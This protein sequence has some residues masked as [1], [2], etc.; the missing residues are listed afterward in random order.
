MACR[1]IRNTNNEIVTVY[2]EN[3]QESKLYNELSTSGLNRLGATINPKQIKEKALELY[4]T[5]DTQLFKDW[6]STVENVQRDSNNEVDSKHLYD[7]AAYMAGEQSLDAISTEMDNSILKSLSDML[8]VEDEFIQNNRPVLVEYL[9]NQLPG[10][11]FTIKENGNITVLNSEALSSTYDAATVQEVFDRIPA[12]I[13]NLQS[14]ETKLT[15]LGNRLGIKVNYQDQVQYTKKDGTKATVKSTANSYLGLINISKGADIRNLTEEM[16]HIVVDSLEAA[17]NPLFYSMYNNIHK[18][19]IYDEVYEKYLPLYGNDTRMIKKEAMAQAIMNTIINDSMITDDVFDS[20]LRRW[21]NKVMEFLST[22]FSRIFMDPYVKTSHLMLEDAVEKANMFTV[23]GS[24]ETYARMEEN[25]EATKDPTQQAIQRTEQSIQPLVDKLK[26]HN[27]SLTVEA[28]LAEDYEGIAP[29][30]AQEDGKVDRYRGLPN[31]P[32]HGM[33]IIGRPSDDT[34]KNFIKKVGKSKAIEINENPYNII[35]RTHGTEGHNTLERISQSLLSR[36]SKAGIA[37][38]KGLSPQYTQG[39]FDKLV[40]AVKK[41]HK[42]AQE[43]E[44]SI[45]GPKGKKPTILLENTI[46]NSDNNPTVAGS[47]DVLVIYSD[48]TAGIFD[49]KFITPQRDPYVTG[50]GASTRLA[51]FPFLDKLDSYDIQVG[52]YKNMLTQNYGISR[53]RQSRIVPIHVRFQYDKVNKEFTDKVVLLQEGTDSQYLEHLPVANEL[54][55]INTIDK[56]IDQQIR[57]RRDKL[58]SYQTA[59]PQERDKLKLQIDKLTQNIQSLQV[60]HDVATTIEAG[61]SLVNEVN[62]RIDENDEVLQDGTINTKYLKTSELLD[63]RERLAFY[64]SIMDAHDYMELVKVNDKK[65]YDKI[66]KLIEKHAA[67]FGLTK[68]R[69]QMKLD[70]RA[71]ELGKNRGVQVNKMSRELGFRSTQFLN[72]SQIQEPA[73]EALYK[74]VDIDN[75]KTRKATNTLV[76]EVELAQRALMEDST[77]PNGIAVYDLILNPKTNNLQ[78]KYKKEFWEA[79]TSALESKDWKF[80][81]QHYKLKEDYKELLKHYKDLAFDAID[82]RYPD[83]INE[84]GNIVGKVQEKKRAA[85]K[86]RWIKRYDVINHPETAWLNK[87]LYLIA[88]L[89]DE[90]MEE[91][92]TE[93][94]NTIRNNIN[95]K[96]FYDLHVTKMLEF[97]KILGAKYGHNFVGNIHRDILDSVFHGNLSMSNLYES[98]MDGLQV[99]EHNL[100]YG[101]RNL[102]TGELKKSVPKLFLIPLK[103]ANDNIDPSLKSKD[104]AK[105]LI[106]MGTAAYNYKHK[107]ETLDEALTLEA[108]LQNNSFGE[109]MRTEAGEILENLAGGFESR[110]TGT[111]AKNLDAFQ[112]FMNYYWYGAKKSSKDVRRKIGQTTIS[113]DRAIGAARNY[114]ALKYLGLAMIPGMATYIGGRVN[115]MYQAI[116][117]RHITKKGLREATKRGLQYDNT[118][119][120][121][122]EHFE[123]YQSDLK[124]RKANDLSANSAT[125]ILTHDNFFAPYR[126]ADEALDRDVLFSMALNHG[127]DETGKIKRLS[128]L[129]EGAKSLVELSTV[130]D[131]KNWKKGSVMN[132]F[133]LEIEGLT[134]AE[135]IRFRNMSRKISR[136]V[137]GSMSNEDVNLVNTSTLG[138][139]MMQFKNWMPGTMEARFGKLEFDSILESFEEGTWKSWSKDQILLEGELQSY[140]ALVAKNVMR[141]GWEIATFGYGAYHADEKKMRYHFDNYVNEMVLLGDE[142]FINALANPEQL[143]VLFA[144]FVDMKRSNIKAFASELRTVIL[145]LMSIMFVGGDFDDDGKAD[146]R[147]TW[148]GR[149]L[150]RLL[151]RTYLEV[152]YYADMNEM[153]RVLTAPMP[154]VRF[155]VDLYRLFANTKD[156]IRDELFGENAPNDPTPFFYYGSDWIPGFNQVGGFFEVFKQDKEK[157]R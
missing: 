146:Y 145:F 87:S 53:I 88:E 122:A 29:I 148:L 19:K 16:A 142:R 94:Y 128:Q 151:N 138:Q 2:T 81:K 149:T 107:S 52:H 144:D 110:R 63:M 95:L 103:D 89:N 119:R 71:I 104:L 50:Y 140:T 17:N 60:R 35:K 121:F 5:K 43:T 77:L 114:L 41:V 57:Q 64:D 21:W 11:E 117:G 36:N 154:I 61:V 32:F 157:T 74:L 136:L 67:A 62:N 40:T 23:I 127:I 143:E 120:A 37:E 124:F 1:I 39:Q 153:Q 8:N 65:L 6:L 45:P 113:T 132:K 156:E 80:F 55:N 42:I 98:M 99:R 78:P 20:R 101:Q 108:M 82:L 14:V 22:L 25:P 31:G 118:Y 86:E 58:I 150:Y 18:H 139:A 91:Y 47:V 44:D 13:E 126:L 155:G 131:N 92:I 73:F 68:T 85:A 75:N 83:T 72:L 79:R 38:A 76:E 111:P 30:L 28:V 33:T 147:D 66:E 133:N 97:K 123:V 109:T 24:N 116:K 15:Q 125:K 105:S 152:G 115:M 102:K 96:N 10:V 134:E 59:R 48:N 4:A 49:W 3:G 100:M 27:D 46:V 106:L 130:K 93:E 12:I 141:L 69:I 137:K 129:P 112:K 7:Y 84:E 54:T 51:E 90:V 26:K 70:E 56:L 9:N 135:Y 34:Q